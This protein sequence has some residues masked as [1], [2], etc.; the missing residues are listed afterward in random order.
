MRMFCILA[1]KMI[2]YVH[3]FTLLMSYIT[4]LS[5]EVFVQR[6]HVSVSLCLLTAQKYKPLSPGSTFFTVN[7]PVL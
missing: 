7:V 4:L 5:T 2:K 1:Q 6:S 3:M